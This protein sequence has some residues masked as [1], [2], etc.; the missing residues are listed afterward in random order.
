MSNTE[1]GNRSETDGSARPVLMVQGVSL[2][3]EYNPE[4]GEW[5]LLEWLQ[6]SANAPGPASQAPPLR[7]TK[8][9]APLKGSAQILGHSHGHGSMRASVPPEGGG[10]DLEAGST[11]AGPSTVPPGRVVQM[12]SRSDAV[13]GLTVDLRTGPGGELQVLLPDAKLQVP[14]EI[15]WGGRLVLSS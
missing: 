1:G 9:D 10:T 13:M 6:D 7:L 4:S 3:C 5:R 2:N 14:H 8:G 11:V 15:R 12:L